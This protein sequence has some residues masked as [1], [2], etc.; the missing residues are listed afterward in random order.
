M[1]DVMAKVVGEKAVA[2]MVNNSIFGLL[3][4]DQF[5]K[6]SRRDGKSGIPEGRPRPLENRSTRRSVSEPVLK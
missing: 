2:G 5:D 1:V 3:K 6:Q 4:L